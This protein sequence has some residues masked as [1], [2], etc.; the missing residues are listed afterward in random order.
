M[1][2]DKRQHNDWTDL[3]EVRQSSFCVPLSRGSNRLPPTFQAAI[4]MIKPRRVAMKSGSAKQEYSTL[5]E[6]SNSNDNVAI[7]LVAVNTKLP[8][9]N[10]VHYELRPCGTQ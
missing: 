6:S 9:K 8:T 1:L 5:V 10:Y 3:I 4:G 7:G 2:N